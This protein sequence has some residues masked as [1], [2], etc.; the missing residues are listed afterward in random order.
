MA[1]RNRPKQTISV[2]SGLG[3]F[4]YVTGQNGPYLLAVD[5]GFYKYVTG[6]SGQY[7]LAMGLDTNGIRVRHRVV[8]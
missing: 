6:Q 1:V 4:K 8:C 5:L 3:L 2:S 7:L